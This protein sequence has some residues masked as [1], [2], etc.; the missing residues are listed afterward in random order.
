MIVKYSKKFPYAPYLNEDIGF[1]QEVDINALTQ[2][3]AVLD[4]L[5]KL[6][7]IAEKFH[8]DN[9]PQLQYQSEVI[10]QGNQPLQSIDRNAIDRLEKLIDDAGTIMELRI[11]ADQAEKLG[12]VQ[13][14]M[15]KLKSLQ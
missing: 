10:P 8:K 14:Y 13:H 6:K 7:A 15:D 4:A 9:N 5:G 11:Y 12:L 1:E 2:P 3:D